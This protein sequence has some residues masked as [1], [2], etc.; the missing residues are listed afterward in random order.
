MSPTRPMAR[1][2]ARPTLGAALWLLTAAAGGQ[3]GSGQP[4]VD[5]EQLEL[6]PP[7]ASQTVVARTAMGEISV[8]DCVEFYVEARKASGFELRV[9]PIVPEQRI[10]EMPKGWVDVL[11]QE[12]AIG[13]L[14]VQK[15]EGMTDR[16]AYRRHRDTV[17]AYLLHYA[18]PAAHAVAVTNAIRPPSEAEIAAEYE[19]RLALYQRPFRFHMR[20]VFISTYEPYVVAQGDTPESIAAKVSGDPRQ[21][22]RI[23]SDADGHPV[24]FVP[25]GERPRRLERP[26]EV[27]ERLWAP[28]APAKVEAARRRMEEVERRAREGE[29]FEGLAERYSESPRRGSL[30]GPWPSG[31]R[32]LQPALLEAARQL[33]PGGISPILKTEAGFHLIQVVEREEEGHLSLAEARPSIIEDDREAQRRRLD[34]A[35]RQEV[36]GLPDLTIEYD[37]IARA[38]DLPD[39]AVVLRLGEKTWPWSQFRST[40]ER[41][42]GPG[43][44][45]RRVF[46]GVQ[47]FVALKQALVLRWA[48]THGLFDGESDEARAYR[49]LER[50]VASMTVFGE[51]VTV[52]AAATVTDDQVRQF[53]D[54][55]R[56]TTFR[57]PQKVSYQV[58]ELWPSAITSGRERRQ[59]LARLEGQLARQLGAIDSIATFQT[60]AVELNP[61]VSSPASPLAGT[62]VEEQLLTGPTAEQLARLAPG[63]WTRK[64][65]RE[66][67]RVRAVALLERRPPRIRPLSEVR[68]A[69]VDGLAKKAQEKV[70]PQVWVEWLREI[71]WESL[72]A[73]GN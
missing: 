41:T 50:V 73:E 31:L 14:A 37:V 9:V 5:A 28:M 36:Y 15:L 32:P 49:A 38:P 27:G 69:I 33:P 1:R 66:G 18:L 19:A 34:R 40:W 64:P 65:Y 24:R 68:Q 52:A 6:V 62:L 22:V 72:P 10:A 12:V 29:P 70:L 54:A 30:T 59:D 17:D 13:R 45:E 26:L 48:E 71:Q 42:I 61:R 7:R 57:E 4:P 21:S 43:A 46:R 8:R 20:D 47:T 25:P 53:Y 56:E 55:V 63:Q 39:E 67:E 11:S 58:I 16:A 44:D 60:L 35:F 2:T 3:S 51:A 23:R